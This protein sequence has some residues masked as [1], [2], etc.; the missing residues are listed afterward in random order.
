MSCKIFSMQE[1]AGPLDPPPLLQLDPVSY[2]V[3]SISYL[4]RRW[5]RDAALPVRA[6]EGYLLQILVPDQFRLDV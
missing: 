4:R 3:D 6:L 2:F 5:H 1:G